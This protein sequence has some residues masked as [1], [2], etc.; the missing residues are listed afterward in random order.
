[1]GP[2]F[3]V[4][5]PMRDNRSVTSNKSNSSKSSWTL[6]ALM[7]RG[8]KVA[9]KLVSHK[10]DAAVSPQDDGSGARGDLGG[11]SSGS[12]TAWSSK[13]WL[14]N[15]GFLDKASSSR[16]APS[17]GE[18]TASRPGTGE[19]APSRPGPR[20]TS[21]LS[22]KTESLAAINAEDED[23]ASAA[24]DSGSDSEQSSIRLTAYQ[25]DLIQ[26]LQ[27]QSVS[28][29][30]SWESHGLVEVPENSAAVCITTTIPSNTDAQDLVEEMA[31]R[32]MSIPVFV[33]LLRSKC[34]PQRAALH[35]ETKAFLQLGAADVVLQP[36]GESPE[37]FVD[38]WLA[39][40]VVRVGQNNRIQ[41]EVE[42]WEHE[43][44]GIL[45]MAAV[46]E[47]SLFWEQSH[48]MLEGIPK[49]NPSLQEPVENKML[50]N[51][52]QVL[53]LINNG[54]FSDVYYVQ[55]DKRQLRA[56]KAV[57]KEKLGSW[58]LVKC[59]SNEVQI[60]RR[61]RH[62][63]VVRFHGSAQSLEHIIILLELVGRRNLF[64][65]LKA[66][67]NDE[68]QKDPFELSEAQSFF[69]QMI[70]ALGYCHSEGVSHR[71]IK[72]ENFA[73]SDKDAII[74]LVDFGMAAELEAPL[75]HKGTMPFVSPEAIEDK[76]TYDAAAAD[77][78]SLGIVLV[79]MVC[80]LHSLSRML[81]WKDT[82]SVNDIHDASDLRDL[83][84]SHGRFRANLKERMRPS[85]PLCSDLDEI[86]HGMLSIDIG[87]RWTARMVQQSPWFNPADQF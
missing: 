75:K 45:Q 20:K 61:L 34:K 39:R 11:A 68:Q 14:P 60:L 50:G 82:M 53:G 38:M 76:S 59:V 1:M 57:K 36:V 56:M 8:K 44:E 28:I 49:L 77:I 54:A 67:D 55:D 81:K 73:I 64:N 40:A 12:K 72:P 74:K 6:D 33:L 9:Q 19:T 66:H 48:N 52:H 31:A 70:S 37:A 22:L 46:R 71:D 23:S 30:H 25:A 80:G 2:T 65:F 24:E 51:H 69:K 32:K 18:T 15:L 3:E 7:S 35:K 41:K 58:E 79:E 27:S 78:W 17:V 26:A 13:D 47:D 86:I 42:D 83:M 62:T 84:G 16:A 85:I 4:L 63:N 87:S 10:D 5:P 29:V 43:I 21:T